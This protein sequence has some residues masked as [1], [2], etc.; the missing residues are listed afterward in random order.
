MADRPVSVVLPGRVIHALR[1]LGVISQPT[2][3]CDLRTCRRLFVPA[4]PRQRCCSERCATALRQRRH[5]QAKKLGVVTVDAGFNLPPETDIGTAPIS[6]RAKNICKNGLISTVGQIRSMTD[7]DLLKFK[8]LGRN[9][10][11][12]LRTL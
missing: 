5:R 9:T 8:G 2:R 6:N 1:A 11:R 12:E 7:W 3:T 4:D 10:L